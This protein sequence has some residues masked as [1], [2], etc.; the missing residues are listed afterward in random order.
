MNIWKIT[1]IVLIL[2]IIS[3]SVLIYSQQETYKFGDFE[4][5]KS[6]LDSISDEIGEEFNNFNICEI[7]SDECIRITKIK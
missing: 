7:D 6:Q 4:I 2:A 1:S 3:L 5:K